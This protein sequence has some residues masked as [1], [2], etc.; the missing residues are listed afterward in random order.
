VKA[1]KWAKTTP[2]Y[3]LRGSKTGFCRKHGEA[4]RVD[5]SGKRT[6]RPAC[7]SFLA[8]LKQLGTGQYLWPRKSSRRSLT[9]LL[10]GDT[11]PRYPQQ[12][13]TD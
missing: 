4:K 13:R 9:C 7:S 2:D 3:K 8:R 1:P 11:G 10:M 12:G 6:F 5:R